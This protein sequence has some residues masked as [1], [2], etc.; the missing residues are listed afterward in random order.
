MREMHGSRNPE[1]E[2]FPQWVDSITRLVEDAQIE[3]FNAWKRTFINIV[4]FVLQEVYN[5]TF[6]EKQADPWCLCQACGHMWDFDDPDQEKTAIRDH[7]LFNCEYMS[8]SVSIPLKHTMN[9]QTFFF[10]PCGAQVESKLL[11]L[12]EVYN[13]Y[14]AL[15]CQRM[16]KERRL[17]LH[18][19]IQPK[20]ELPLY[21]IPKE[22]LAVTE[23]MGIDA[24]AI[25]IWDAINTVKAVRRRYE[26]AMHTLGRNDMFA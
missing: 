6:D 13:Y 2:N 12:A 16:S 5:E 23:D 9:L 7:I 22:I 11:Y 8:A 18:P 19:E 20:L 4:D 17:S 15:D 24:A 3:W 25:N 21:T 14:M 10:V 1:R 26:R